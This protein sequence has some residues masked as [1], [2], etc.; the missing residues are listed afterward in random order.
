M[1]RRCYLIAVDPN[2]DC[3]QQIEL[4]NNTA[5]VIGRAP[6]YE[7]RDEEVSRQQL[8]VRANMRGQRISIE[9][10]GTNPA[11]LRG[12]ELTPHMVYTANHGD[13][14]DIIANK[15]KYRVHFEDVEDE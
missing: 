8:R 1:Y 7:I 10:I 4:Q 15:Y 14:I 13:I 9:M 11:A 3:L 6:K 5:I 12:N 2:E